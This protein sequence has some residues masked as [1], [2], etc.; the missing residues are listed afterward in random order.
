MKNTI[1]TLYKDEVDEEFS[2]ENPTKEDY[3]LA[4][5][6]IHTKSV[7]DTIPNYPLNKKSHLKYTKVNRSWTGRYELNYLDLDQDTADT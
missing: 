5:K 2:T 6:A 1:T 7:Q 4:I 3:K